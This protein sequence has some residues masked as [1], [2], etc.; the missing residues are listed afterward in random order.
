MIKLMNGG[1]VYY[2]NWDQSSEAVRLELN[3]LWN[4]AYQLTNTPQLSLEALRGLGDIP[5]GQGFSIPVYG[6]QPCY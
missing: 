6:N 3:E 4:K 2:L 5:S 1:K